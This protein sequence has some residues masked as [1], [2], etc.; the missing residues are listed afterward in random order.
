M[1]APA[2]RPVDDVPDIP[3]EFD[4]FGLDHTG[5]YAIFATAGG[6]ALPA[7]VR[8]ALRVHDGLRAGIAVPGVRSPD[9]P[10]SYARVGLFVYEWSKEQ[11]G[12]RRVATPTGAVPTSLRTELALCKD[13]PVLNIDDFREVEALGSE[14]WIWKKSAPNPGHAAA[15]DTCPK[16]GTR[17]A[18]RGAL[19][20]VPGSLDLASAVHDETTLLQ[21]PHCRHRFRAMDA[22]ILGLVEPSQLRGGLMLL[23]VVLAG[24]ALVR[25]VLLD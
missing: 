12:Y 17:F 23:L 20:E 22:R 6:G 8:G 4:W 25:F 3:P 18:T 15:R 13:V 9:F 16:C 14:A 1:P 10:R 11:G 19:I 24:V 5:Q 7:T 21:C 2:E